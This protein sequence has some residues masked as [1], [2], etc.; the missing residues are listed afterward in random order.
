M[1]ISTKMSWTNL[2]K[3]LIQNGRLSVLS[4]MVTLFIGFSGY[5]QKLEDFKKC[6]ASPSIATLPYQKIKRDAISLEAAK[7]RAFSATNGYGFDKMEDEKDA[8]L[9]KIK[10]E[11]K[12]LEDAEEELEEDKKIAPTVSSPWERKV[13]DSKRKLEDL[14]DDIT[15][16]NRKIDV[17]ID[18]FETLQEARGKVREIF[19]DVDDELYN[20]LNRPHVHIGPKPSSSDREAYDKWNDKYKELKGYIEDIGD[21]VDDKARTHKEQEDGA[22]NVVTKLKA[23]KRKTSI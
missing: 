17:A 4:T 6:A 21:V 19:D 10:A 16:V 3:A 7:K 13:A 9:R 14:D 12:K 18:K 8:I 20:S 22:G 11:K 5:S 1:N 2:S 15:D 23:L